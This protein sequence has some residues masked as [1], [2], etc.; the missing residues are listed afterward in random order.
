MNRVD[1]HGKHSPIDQSPW[2]DGIRLAVLNGVLSLI[3]I[4]SFLGILALVVAISAWRMNATGDP[5]SGIPFPVPLLFAL[6][7]VAFIVGWVRFGRS[8]AG[9]RQQ[10]LRSALLGAA[11]LFGLS[12]LG[13]A[14]VVW[15]LVFGDF[16]ANQMLNASVWVYGMISTLILLAGASCVAVTTSVAGRNRA[17]FS[18]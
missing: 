13:Y 8:M 12:L 11:P 14:S 7:A 4:A 2:R 17:S 15:M 3:C 1:D 5:R 16:T 18:A 9:T 10:V 6:Y